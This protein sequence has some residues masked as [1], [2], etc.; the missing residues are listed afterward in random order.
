MTGFMLQLRRDN[1]IL[2]AQDLG[3]GSYRIGGDLTCDIIIP[4]ITEGTV[5]TLI[6]DQSGNQAG[7]ALISEATGL[8]ANNENLEM[9]ST[10]TNKIKLNFNYGPLEFRVFRNVEKKERSTAIFA[11]LALGLALTAAI[12]QYI[13]SRPPEPIVIAPKVEPTT[14]EGQLADLRER[15]QR[16]NI[17]ADLAERVKLSATQNALIA[18]GTLSEQEYLRW[19]EITTTLSTQDQGLLR[20]RV[21]FET[22]GNDM[23]QGYVWSP[24]PYV[25]TRAGERFKAG[26][27]LPSGWIVESVTS[28]GAR[29]KRDESKIDI[30]LP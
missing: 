19:R 27:T 8:T 4:D 6:I 28:K 18:T 2:L 15:L 24:Q 29:L 26:D 12:T 9:G 1:E 20:N 11:F 14:V 13:L 22:F 10:L 25:I 16:R 30:V 23:V 5:A 17:A 21:D 7:V 3:A